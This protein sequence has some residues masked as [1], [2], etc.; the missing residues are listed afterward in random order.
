MLYI[1][2]ALLNI[3]DFVITVF[4]INRYC[5]NIESNPLVSLIYETAGVWAMLVYK[6]FITSFVLGV[7]AYIRKEKAFLSHLIL[8]FGC[9]TMLFTVIYSLYLALI[10]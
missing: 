10:F 4:L 9:V 6:I 1:L 8:V 3:A 5:S 2:Y 7:V